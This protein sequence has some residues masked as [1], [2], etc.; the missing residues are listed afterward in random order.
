M[1]DQYV[2]SHYGDE[3]LLLLLNMWWVITYITQHVM[4]HYGNE[5]LLLLLNMWWVIMVMRHFFYYS[6]ITAIGVMIECMYICNELLL[7]GIRTSHV[8]TVA[9]SHY[10]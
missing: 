4:S 10:I 6:I 2:T 3:S 8:T 7:D 1:S 9:V 5:S